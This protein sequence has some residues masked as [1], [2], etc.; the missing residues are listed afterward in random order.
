M[1]WR[2]I[3]ETGNYGVEDRWG[4]EIHGNSLLFA[5]FFVNLK[6]L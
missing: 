2:A 1:G 3:R 6:L 4:E 5:Q